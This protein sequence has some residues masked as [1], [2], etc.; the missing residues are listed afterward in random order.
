MSGNDLIET[1]SLFYNQNE[2]LRSIPMRS[3]KSFSTQ[4]ES[5]STFPD[6]VVHNHK[7]AIAEIYDSSSPYMV[8]LEIFNLQ[9]DTAEIMML[10]PHQY[11][12]DTYTLSKSPEFQNRSLHRHNFFEFMFVLKGSVR[13]RIEEHHLT[14]HTGQCCLLNPNVK[15]VEEPVENTEILFLCLSD[16][17]FKLIIKNDISYENNRNLQS[18]HTPIYHMILKALENQEYYQ[19]QYVDFLPI[20]PFSTLIPELESLVGRIISETRKKEPA[21][22]IFI[23]GLMARIIA[24]LINPTRYMLRFVSLKNSKEEYIF[25]QIQQILEENNGRITRCELSNSL[26]YEEHYLNKIVKSQTG[27]SIKE[28]SQIFLL[29]EAARML[30]HTNLNITDIIHKLG[31]SNCSYFYRIFEERYG[32]TPKQYRQTSEVR[33]TDCLLFASKIRDEDTY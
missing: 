29:R 30:I 12:T 25:S 3:E 16:D 11:K 31:L 20:V 13:Q 28:Y 17:F 14:Y 18:N 8:V 23:Q 27:K 26:N 9:Y 5:Y 2:F 6:L 1:I 24:L 33:N 22:F 4:T 32:L 10:S 7:S 19:K 15:H 21:F